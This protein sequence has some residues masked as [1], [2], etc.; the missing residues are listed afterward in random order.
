MFHPF[1][2]LSQ[3]HGH[4]Q[5]TNFKPPRRLLAAPVLQTGK[6]KAWGPRQLKS[7]LGRRLAPMRGVLPD[8]AVPIVNARP[9]GS[10]LAIAQLISERPLG[11]H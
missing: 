4:H 11:S 2:G 6:P 3:Q 7:Q 8:Y 5:G 10:E 9:D 1:A